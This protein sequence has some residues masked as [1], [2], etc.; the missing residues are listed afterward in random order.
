MGVQDEASKADIIS[1]V[2]QLK[3]FGTVEDLRRFF[4]ELGSSRVAIDDVGAGVDNAVA[5]GQ[6]AYKAFA[7]S[8]V[9][10][11]PT[12]RARP[13]FTP[14]AIREDRIRK[15]SS[16]TSQTAGA[17]GIAQQ[18]IASPGSF[19]PSSFQIAAESPGAGFSQTLSGD[20]AVPDSFAVP[21]APQ[22]AMSLDILSGLRRFNPD[23]LDSGAAVTAAQPGLM[24]FTITPSGQAT[25]ASSALDELLG[26]LQSTRPFSADAAPVSVGSAETFFPRLPDTFLNQYSTVSFDVAGPLSRPDA[27]GKKPWTRSRGIWDQPLADRVREARNRR[28]TGL[29]MPTQSSFDQMMSGL[30]RDFATRQAP[31]EDVRAAVDA[32][33]AGNAR[34]RVSEQGRVLDSAPTTI[35]GPESSVVSSGDARAATASSAAQAEET[36]KLLRGAESVMPQSSGL[37][38]DQLRKL[39]AAGLGGEAKTPLAFKTV[40]MR[41]SQARPGPATLEKMAQSDARIEALRDAVETDYPDPQAVRSR[42]AEISRALKSGDAS[43]SPSEFRYRDGDTVQV[44]STPDRAELRAERARLLEKL[45]DSEYPGYAEAR[46]RALEEIANAEAAA[47]ESQNAFAATSMGSSSVADAQQ[48]ILDRLMLTSGAFNEQEFF[49]AAEDLF[50]TSSRGGA[51][52]APRVFNAIRTAA[53]NYGIPEPGDADIIFAALS[54]LQHPVRHAMGDRGLRAAAEYIARGLSARTISEPSGPAAPLL[55]VGQHDRTKSAWEVIDEQFSRIA[56]PM[57]DAPEQTTLPAVYDQ[58][59]PPFLRLEATRDNLDAAF[60]G[61][62]IEEAERALEQ[63]SA[64]ESAARSVPLPPAQDP[65]RLAEIIASAREA[66]RRRLGNVPPSSRRPMTLAESDSQNLRLRDLER[67]VAEA[68][69]AVEALS[70]NPVASTERQLDELAQFVDEMRQADAYGGAGETA[71]QFASRREAA[72]SRL[73]KLQEGLAVERRFPKG[74]SPELLAARS[75]LKD[76]QDRLNAARAE[77]PASDQS[78]DPAFSGGTA[79][80]VQAR[81]I[82]LAGRRASLQR[83]AIAAEA[84]SQGDVIDRVKQELDAVDAEIDALYSGQAGAAL[85]PPRVDRAPAQPARLPASMYAAPSP[86]KL[87]SADDLRDAVRLTP[88]NI[89]Y[90]FVVPKE[91]ARALRSRVN[92]ELARMKITRET[93]PDE[94]ALSGLIGGGEIEGGIRFTNPSD[95]SRLP[96]DGSVEVL[97]LDRDG[98]PNFYDPAGMDLRQPTARELEEILAAESADA[99]SAARMNRAAEDRAIATSSRLPPSAVRTASA[100]QVDEALPPAARPESERPV[101]DQ[102]NVGDSG[103]GS[104]G[105]SPQA[106][107]LA[108]R[109]QNARNRSTAAQADADAATARQRQAEADAAAREAARKGEAAT[110]EGPA[111]TG[112]RGNGRRVLGGAIG[113]GAALAGGG[114]AID[115]LAGDD[116]QASPILASSLVYEPPQEDRNYS[117]DDILDRVRRA[118]QYQSYLVSGNMMPR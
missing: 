5:R 25:L 89:S 10:A 22:A 49:K 26:Q 2:E 101:F 41:S 31:E 61:M 56:G 115:Y 82:T 15:L 32:I 29:G 53:R 7:D 85:N 95:L 74:E 83:T 103:M 30:Q 77:A 90:A 84:S 67:D 64:A 107:R 91:T 37:T 110:S 59:I 3:R 118:R 70:R 50:G 44:K 111:A 78:M 106:A 20:T 16:A 96:T 114:S 43:R 40:E 19:G 54:D 34:T 9:S 4:E 55:A 27:V 116:V 28:M 94:V 68:S 109:A 6:M 71:E 75:D 81:L 42:L 88:D 13:Q 17:G 47:R 73:K 117:A 108:R 11:P 1:Q 92:P 8:E 86:V 69:A 45:A 35:I 46:N 12:P 21:E 51:V 76:A 36:A 39:V 112:R 65:A 52:D 100:T 93:G 18:D 97:H 113:I 104:T 14:D 58:L 33:L 102:S 38:R 80:D 99:R 87:R 24:D 105:E 63:L 62:S 79:G 66:G 48:A 60:G 98:R 23:L 57:L 72:L